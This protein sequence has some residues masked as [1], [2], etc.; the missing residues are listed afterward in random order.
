MCRPVNIWSKNTTQNRFLRESF[1][2]TQWTFGYLKSLEFLDS[3]SNYQHFNKDLT[4]RSQ[5]ANYLELKVSQSCWSK[6]WKTKTKKNSRIWSSHSDDYEH[7]CLLGYN[8]VLAIWFTLLSCLAFFSTLKME[9]TCSSATPIDFQR[10]TWHC[11]PEYGTLQQSVVAR[12]I[13]HSKIT[14]GCQQSTIS[15]EHC[16]DLHYNNDL[17]DQMNC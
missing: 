14:M 10:T 13:C 7:F 16:N 2:S 12:K 11:I 8:A 15:N 6:V 5:T 3:L 1:M 9:A 17:E 4:P